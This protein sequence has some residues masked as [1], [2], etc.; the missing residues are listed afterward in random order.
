[1]G[2]KHRGSSV[3]E[4]LN[5][6][7]K[8]PEFRKGFE[9]ARARQRMAQQ[10]YDARKRAGLSQPEL[11]RRLHTSQAAISRMESGG[12]NM[13]IDLI[14]SIARA[15]GGRFEGHIVRDRKL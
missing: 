3:R 10:I 6:E 14:D 4:W 11:A 7:L 13:T 12:Q 15:L 5:E 8:D 1:M 9:Q 2:N